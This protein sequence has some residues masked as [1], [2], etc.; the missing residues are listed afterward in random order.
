MTSSD[1]LTLITVANTRL[2]LAA[3]PDDPMVRL[4]TFDRTVRQLGLDQDLAL[5]AQYGAHPEEFPNPAP[6]R[7]EERWHG[8]EYT[9]AREIGFDVYDALSKRHGPVKLRA[10]SDGAAIS[11]ATR[12]CEEQAEF[13]T[14]PK[15]ARTVNELAAAIKRDH[16]HAEGV[17]LNRMMFAARPDLIVQQ[18]R[19]Y[20]SPAAAA[21]PAAVQLAAAE[22]D[23][24]EQWSEDALNDW[25]TRHGSMPTQRERGTAFSAYAKRHPERVPQGARWMFRLGPVPTTEVQATPARVAFALGPIDSNEQKYLDQ[26][27]AAAKKWWQQQED[28]DDDEA[29]AVEAFAREFP[30]LCPEVVARM[31]DGLGMEV[32][33]AEKDASRAANT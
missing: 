24:E 33:R 32:K 13:R 30:Q 14:S 22:H 6:L 31:F 19:S 8:S 23:R 26:W 27:T 2:Q 10:M 12:L 28:G 5:R 3:N 16:R 4:E 1:R 18:A 7:P 29:K 21:S 11:A 20:G 25:R 17:E 9:R 15:D